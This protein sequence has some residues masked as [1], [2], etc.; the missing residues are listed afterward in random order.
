MAAALTL[1]MGALNANAQENMPKAS[2]AIADQL[3]KLLQ[4]IAGTPSS[5]PKSKFKRTRMVI[6]LERKAKYKVFSLVSP[7]RV[8]LQLPTMRTKL[9]IVEPQTTDK[10]TTLITAVRS[11]KSGPGQT[12]VIFN[13]AAPVIVEN[14]Q[15][16]SLPNGKGAQLTLD[17]VPS[18]I[19]KEI[20]NA[21]SLASGFSLGGARVKP[22]MP[23]AA[24]KP[25][26]IELRSHKHIIVLDP[27]HGGQDS[28]AKKHGVKEK[29]VVLA[30][31]LKLREHLN[32]TGRYKVL[33]TRSSDEFIT[34]SNRRKFAERHKAALFISIHADYAKSQAS[35]ATIYSLRKSVAEALKKSTKRN[36]AR[37][38][39]LTAKERQ[40]LKNLKLASS[41]KTLG[42]ILEDLA[43]RDVEA[44]A[45]QTNKFTET[46]IRH[47]G[48]TTT[49]RSRPHRTAAFRVLKTATMPAVLIE[50]AYVSNRN[51]A[52]RLKSVEWRTKVS[53]SIARAVDRYFAGV[54][55]LPL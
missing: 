55:R 46:V 40:N 5:P 7:N 36:V 31:A 13:V 50:L 20:V 25:K 3:T 2:N 18:D 11:G 8:V 16:K 35:G 1:F 44:T 28:G 38:T 47:M 42:S 15:M 32:A 34:L 53:T 37:R 45:F 17:I 30:F 23:Q 12:R 14:A 27:G 10:P 24:A 22:P 26:D 41:A 43:Q 9:P 54:Q 19:R 33:M 48:Q 39:L 29:N 52:R 51:D 4:S 6:E 49:M 21:E